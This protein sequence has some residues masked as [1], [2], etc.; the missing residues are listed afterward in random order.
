MKNKTSLQKEG[1]SLQHFK[2]VL[3]W[4]ESLYKLD[5]ED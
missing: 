3:Q 1:L 5:I 2:Y 4:E